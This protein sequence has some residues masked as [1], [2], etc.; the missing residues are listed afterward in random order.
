MTF[1]GFQLARLS[2]TIYQI[3]L[4]H[5]WQKQVNVFLIIDGH[6][7]L[8]DSGHYHPS[9]TAPF[10][11]A[12]AQLGL[13]VRDISQILYSH[14]HIDH[15][16]GG[17]RLANL[18]NV[19]HLAHPGIIPDLVDYYAYSNRNIDLFKKFIH[20]SGAQL[21]PQ[22][23]KDISKFFI[24]YNMPEVE[25]G[26]PVVM[27]IQDRDHITVGRHRDFLAR[28]TPG[29]T[30]CDISFYDHNDD[31]LFVG[32]LMSAQGNTMLAE[33]LHSNLED[34]IKSL[35]YV[36]DLNPG[37]VL[38]A[39]GKII[40]FPDAL[41]RKA[42]KLAYLRENAILDHLNQKGQTICDI[43]LRLSKNSTASPIVFMRYLGL[44][45]THLNSLVRAGKVKEEINE[46]VTIYHL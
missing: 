31:V 13:S 33:V 17:L 14:S 22:H 32:D 16:G 26:I 4:S 25:A 9:S 24:E 42:L 46:G 15:V 2:P 43:S 8:I 34:Y 12:L 11:Q 30:A 28:Y 23:V 38:P 10:R 37:K 44:T 6:I 29:H 19:H 36:L 39:H 41:F 20:R 7:T 45:A 40:D 35:H 5:F 21:F 27:P 1:H 3:N 18:P